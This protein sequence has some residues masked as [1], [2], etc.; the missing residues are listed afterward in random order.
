MLY[1]RRNC[2]LRLMEPRQP[3]TIGDFA[4]NI[5]TGLAPRMRNAPGGLRGRVVHVRDVGLRLAPPDELEEIDLPATPDVERCRLRAGDVL[6][7]SRGVAVRAAVASAHHAGTVA[8]P[9]LIVMRL[10]PNM[11]PELLTVLLR[12]PQAQAALLQARAGSGT[13][14]FTVAQLAALPIAL[15]DLATQRTLA[16]IASLADD[17]HDAAVKAAEL[18]REA[19]LDLVF[20]TLTPATVRSAHSD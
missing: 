12:H 14:G 19:V 10:G 8:G 20:D 1:V 7:T 6:V 16:D 2:L 3:R 9:N 15:P 4:T 18:R 13:A 5:F 11:V 17:Y